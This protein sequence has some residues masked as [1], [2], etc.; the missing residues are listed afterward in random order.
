ML[1]KY[2]YQCM[3]T[4]DKKED[5]THKYEHDD[6]NKNIYETNSKEG[7]FLCDNFFY[8]VE[9]IQNLDEF[10][11]N[12]KLPENFSQKVIE[13][14]NL[15]ERDGYEIDESNVEELAYLYKV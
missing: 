2:I 9:N 8:G 3:M 6:G 4:C 15:L 10:D 5:I 7:F 1:L 14:E 11:E 12:F 13:L